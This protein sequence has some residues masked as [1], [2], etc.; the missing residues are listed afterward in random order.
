MLPESS[1]PVVVRRKIPFIT[2]FLFFLLF[3]AGLI[4]VVAY[5]TLFP[6]DHT[7]I[8]MKVAYFTLSTSEFTKYALII[9][10]IGFLAILPLYTTARIYKKAILTFQFNNILISGNKVKYE[11][12]I[13]SLVRVYCM[14]SK[15]LSGQSLKKLTLYFEQKGKKT[16][17]VRLSNYDQADAFMG[18]LMLYE[19][20]KFI[21]YDFDVSPDSFS[22][23]K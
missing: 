12:L 14:D 21:S 16:I 9:T 7:S 3:G 6:T 17:R 18:K 8:E 2:S 10:F 22:D 23:E 19:N 13:D 20:I 15:N 11:I 5:I 4:L 1:F